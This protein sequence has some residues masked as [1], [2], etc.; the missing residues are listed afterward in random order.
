[1]L[2]SPSLV[3]TITYSPSRGSLLCL[4]SFC[5][6][7]KIG[8]TYTTCHMLGKTKTSFLSKQKLSKKQ[9]EPELESTNHY[10]KG[11]KVHEA[12]ALSFTFSIAVNFW[13][14]K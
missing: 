10:S 3:V 7:G 11:S 12:Y 13:L 4:S 1:M 6:I 9:R 5:E 8:A 2:T 14:I